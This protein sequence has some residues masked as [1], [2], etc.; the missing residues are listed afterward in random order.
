MLA[1]VKCFAGLERARKVFG[2]QDDAIEVFDVIVESSKR[3]VIK[4]E[5]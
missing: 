5:H 3:L 2:I 4:D 1:R